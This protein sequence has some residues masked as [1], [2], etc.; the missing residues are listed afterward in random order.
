MQGVTETLQES[1][2]FKRNRLD[3]VCPIVCCQTHLPVFAEAPRCE[4]ILQHLADY[5]SSMVLWKICH[6]ESALENPLFVD[7]MNGEAHTWLRP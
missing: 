7:V 1:P 3:D 6:Q 5:L 4:C 2:V